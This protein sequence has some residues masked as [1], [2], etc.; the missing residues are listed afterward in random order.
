[1]MTVSGAESGD[2]EGVD[3]LLKVQMKLCTIVT[4]MLQH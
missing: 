1:M 2:N 3:F 4:E